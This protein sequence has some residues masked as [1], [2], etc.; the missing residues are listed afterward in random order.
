MQILTCT[1]LEDNPTTHKEDS[2]GELEELEKSEE[3][4]EGEGSDGSEDTEVNG[5]SV[6]VHHRAALAD[7]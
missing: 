2:S 5:Q 3:L 6:A 7:L 4:E 1:L